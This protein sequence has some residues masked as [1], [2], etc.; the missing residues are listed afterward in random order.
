MSQEL[1][2]GKIAGGGLNARE[3]TFWW[4]WVAAAA[5]CAAYVA[6]RPRAPQPPNVPT[7][8]LDPAVAKLI[9]GTLAEV[10]TAPES[11]AAWGKLGS[12]LMHYE[13][14]DEATVA[15]AR[16]ERLAPKEP[17]WPYLHALLL[18]P[19]EPGAALPH[20]RRA[21][22]LSPERP[23]AP[24][25]RLAQ[26]LAERGQSAEA[27]ALF[28]D[29]RRADPAHAPALLGLARLRQN[30]GRLADSSNLLVRCL[31]NPHTAKAAHL[32]L[33]A[34]QQ[35]QGHSSAVA[36]TARQ[37]ANLPA[38]APWPDPW[39]TEAL[40]WRVGRKARL[41]DASALIDQ[42]QLAP[43]AQLLAAVSRDYPG[44]EEAWYQLGWTLNQSQQF[45][46][47]ERALRE[48]LRLSP[49]SPKGHAQLAVA[50]LAQRRHAEAIDVLR[51]AIVLKPTWR[52]LHSNLGYACVQLGR[53]DE[54][55]GH[56]R[57]AL[58]HD[59][60][61]VPSYTALADLLTRRSQREEARR[62]L[63]QALELNPADPRANGLLQ[64]L[65]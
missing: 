8:G 57:H 65:N 18:L 12:V 4:T 41:E 20:L 19:R 27:A 46:D 48:H 63:R 9:E 31:T 50:L 64:Q 44:D 22:A 60:N 58:L 21:T 38:D 30:E 10:R 5:L 35:T 33:A 55:I 3:R 36:E 52:E 34:V 54:A 17:R 11:A 16:A 13:F 23:D 25:L 14:L 43:A 7:A 15:F 37:L 53:L 59:P 39:W 29:L 1:R 42:G 26:F 49:R 62:L 56:Y 24:R 32:T 61:Y 6:L 28:D 45:A 51:A 2:N 40:A 47:A